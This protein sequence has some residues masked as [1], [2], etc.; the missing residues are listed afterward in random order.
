MSSTKYLAVYSISAEV[1][2]SLFVLDRSWEIINT[3]LVVSF[4]RPFPAML[5]VKTG[6]GNQLDI[7]S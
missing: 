2:D 7:D 4:M 1:Q 3:L 6:P 5:A